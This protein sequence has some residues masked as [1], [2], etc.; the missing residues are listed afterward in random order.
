MEMYPLVLALHEADLEASKLFEDVSGNRYFAEM[1]TQLVRV[2]KREE[3]DLLR[4]MEVDD[5]ECPFH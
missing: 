4:G 1:V 3:S 2:Q 5:D